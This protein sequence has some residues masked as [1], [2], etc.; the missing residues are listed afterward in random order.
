MKKILSFQKFERLSGL[1]N[2]RL[3]KRLNRA[4]ERKET[5]IEIDW[6]EYFEVRKNIR[7]ETDTKVLKSFWDKEKPNP[8]PDLEHFRQEYFSLVDAALVKN[9]R[10][11]R[12]K[13][14]GIKGKIKRK[15][16]KFREQKKT[17]KKNLS[18]VCLVREKDG[19]AQSCPISETLKK[20]GHSV[21][22]LPFYFKHDQLLEYLD[23]KPVDA[24]LRRE[25]HSCLF[26]NKKWKKTVEQIH[27]KGVLPLFYDCG[28]LGHYS[29]FVI[30]GYGKDGRSFI[31]DEFE[32]LPEVIDWQN[33]PLTI[34]TYRNVFLGR[35]ER[36]KSLNPLEETGKDYVVVWLQYS[37]SL[38]KKQFRSKSVE[39]WAAKACSLLKENGLNPVVK[40]APVGPFIKLDGIPIFSDKERAKEDNPEII[41]NQEGILNE[42]LIAHAKYH[43]LISSSVTNEL[44]LA[45]APIITMGRSWFNGLEIFKEAE[46][47]EDILVEPE[48]NEGNRNKWLNWWIQRQAPKKEVAGILEK[49][50]QEKKVEVRNN[51]A[52]KEIYIAESRQWRQKYIDAALEGLKKHGFSTTSELKRGGTAICFGQWAQRRLKK[53]GGRL[54]IMEAGFIDRQKWF[55]IQFDDICG[56]A[57]VRTPKNKGDRFERNFGH[58]VKPWKERKDGNIVVVGQVKADNNLRGE[59]IEKFYND[60]F[61]YFKDKGKVVFKTHPDKRFSMPDIPDWAEIDNRDMKNVLED[62]RILVTCSSNSAVDSILAG[63]PV[64][65]TSKRSIAYRVLSNKFEDWPR[66]FD[67]KPFLDDLAWRQWTMK[68][69][70]SGLFWDSIKHCYENKN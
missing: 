25:E 62:A 34:Q 23:R 56:M 59:D 9:P 6:H 28:Y 24:V 16:N 29:S 51:V 57:D 64:I 1:L 48:I 13:L 4:A 50:V 69:I 11:P 27:Q 52:K 10:C 21:E 31:H 20:V 63:V 53:Q 36:A 43:V 39:E 41:V 19:V 18:L 67:R 15:I 37:P 35:L 47:W 14:N 58:L 54:L 17:T 70:R 66:P 60:A 61:D 42:R 32:S 55:S 7:L 30:D 38:L 8:Y 68:E 3:R 5:H 12:C 22:V 33:A 40:C 26:A 45:N 44:V 46:T 2:S 49:F 65:A